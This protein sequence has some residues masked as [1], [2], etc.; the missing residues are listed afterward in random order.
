[1]ARR[2]STQDLTMTALPVSIPFT[3]RL[4]TQVLWTYV[5]IGRSTTCSCPEKL[6]FRNGRHVPYCHWKESFKFLG[7]PHKVPWVLDFELHGYL[8]NRT[9]VTSTTAIET[10]GTLPGSAAIP[11]NKSQELWWW[12]LL[13]SRIK[14]IRGE[15][16]VVSF[17]SDDSY[18]KLQARR[19]G[20]QHQKTHIRWERKLFG[21]KNLSMSAES[22]WVTQSARRS[23]CVKFVND[24][25]E[26]KCLEGKSCVESES[27]LI[28][29]CGAFTWYPC[30]TGCLNI[31]IDLTFRC[32]FISGNSMFCD[33]RR[34][35]QKK[36]ILRTKKKSN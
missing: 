14:K 5:K 26:F 18:D 10:E 24:E 17:V 4:R 31:C 23:P 15:V 8:K 29:H 22:N 9:G 1:M 28:V 13:Y 3:Q 7:S 36:S 12:L 35:D 19:H 6:N 34:R 21:N 30:V 20:E 25:F 16:S 32:N 33:Q 2:I 27:C 11:L